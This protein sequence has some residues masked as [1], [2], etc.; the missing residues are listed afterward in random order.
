MTRPPRIDP[1]WEEK[2]ALGHQQRYPWD[3]VVSFVFRNTPRNL[4]AKDIHILEVGCGTGGNVWFAAR[5]GY[6]I[7][8]I[9]GSRSAIARAKE[10]LESDGLHADLR[11][12][13]FDDLPYA[14]N[15][16]SLVIDRGALCCVGRAVLRQ[17]IAEIQRVLR[18]GGRFLFTPF[19]DDHSS[20][21]S[22]D[23]DADGLAGDIREGTLT[24]VGRILFLS[25]RDIR[26]ALA[27]GWSI[28]SITLRREVDWTTGMAGDCHSLWRVTAT[29]KK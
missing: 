15:S 26:E 1:V 11:V 7:A 27:D 18:P 9:D 25:E 2:Y 8:G 6:T 28:D 16:F 23:M 21:A 19:A 13:Y 12:A 29:A 20:L 5:E 4:P 22:A 17:S 10:R 24:G 3:D 14:A